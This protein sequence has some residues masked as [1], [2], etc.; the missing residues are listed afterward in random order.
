MSEYFLK[1]EPTLPGFSG[2]NGF[3]STERYAR[4]KGY[5]Q[6]KNILAVNSIII[7]FAQDF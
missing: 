4:I 5:L 1:K 7:F 6:N 3:S 2:E